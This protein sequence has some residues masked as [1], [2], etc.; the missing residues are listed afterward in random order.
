MGK[1]AVVGK[2]RLGLADKNGW[3]PAI[4]LATILLSALFLVVFLS[5]D[6]ESVV[7]AV[8]AVGVAAVVL[9]AK[10]GVTSTVARAFSE[11]ENV[12]N[13]AVVL[14]VLGIALV[15]HEDYF[16]LLMISSVLIVTLA[17]IGLNIQFGYVGILNFAG[18]SF[19]GVGGYTAALGLNTVIPPLLVV[20]LS[21]V[22]AAV[23]GC[24]II[25]PVLRTRS[26]YA[27]LVTIAFALLFTIFL[28]V[29]PILGG[30]Q[31]L[32]VEAM[33]VLGWQFTSN[34]SIGGLFELS[35]YFNYVLLALVLVSV[36][37]IFVRRLERSWIGVNMDASRLD[38]TASAC[39]GHKIARWRIIAFTL[40]NFLI[41]IAGALSAMAHNYIAPSNFTFEY[42][43]LLVAVVL[44]GGVGS[45]WGVV[46]ASTIVVLLPEKLQI[47]QEYRF[48]LF[49]ILVILMLLF[50]PAGLLPRRMRNYFP[51]RSPRK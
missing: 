7:A 15:F 37:F 49:A 32:S 43:M 17:C 31:G 41:G 40:G 23:V 19:L 34:V 35:F 39:F 44:L 9:A 5:A 6:N 50:R 21:G 45:L 42:S 10:T 26:H 29:N 30:P 51:N 47:I 14:S 20:L 36:A 8:L 46:V 24:I 13:A 38:E 25:L 11:Y 33:S 48:L 1:D 2:S 12:M 4:G 3:T 18:A 22:M 16:V 28:Q 27:A